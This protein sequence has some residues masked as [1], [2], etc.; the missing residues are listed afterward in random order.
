MTEDG[1]RYRD[2]DVYAFASGVGGGE[3]PVSAN[4]IGGRGI[5]R[6]ETGTMIDCVC[7]SLIGGE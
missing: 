2:E 1:C 5:G 4:C 7:G 6:S 3:T